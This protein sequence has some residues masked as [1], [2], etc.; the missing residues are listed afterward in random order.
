MARQFGYFICNNRLIILTRPN[1]GNSRNG[2]QNATAQILINDVI[3]TVKSEARMLV[4]DWLETDAI[5]SNYSELLP[6]LRAWA[7]QSGVR[8]YHV[9]VGDPHIRELLQSD[10]LWPQEQ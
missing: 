9:G 7:E 8:W 1:A 2:A 4:V 10:G 6:V 3:P 5:T